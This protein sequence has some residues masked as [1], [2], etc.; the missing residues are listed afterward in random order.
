MGPEPRRRRS[1]ILQL[2]L[3]PPSHRPPSGRGLC[4]QSAPPRRTRHQQQGDQGTV[5]LPFPSDPRR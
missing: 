2:Q 4:P 3:R 1:P 5:G